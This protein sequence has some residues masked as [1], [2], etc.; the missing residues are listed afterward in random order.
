MR[1]S[2]PIKANQSLHTLLHT[3][4][5]PLI[6][7]N[8]FI[9]FFIIIHRSAVRI[10]EAP[11]K[12]SNE[13]KGLRCIETSLTTAKFRVPNLCTLNIKPTRS[14]QVWVF[15]LAQKCIPTCHSHAHP[16]HPPHQ[17]S[18]WTLS[19]LQFRLNSL[20]IDLGECHT[21][22]FEHAK[23]PNRGLGLVHT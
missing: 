12:I 4:K 3:R 16:Y 11:P 5:R 8:I 6:Y 19:P 23:T 15:L 18:L 14:S 13:I 10:R 17:Q 22:L 20:P 7:M 2:T 9:N 21:D 1:G